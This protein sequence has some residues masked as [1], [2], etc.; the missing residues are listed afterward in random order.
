MTIAKRTALLMRWRGI[1]SQSQLARISGVA[2]SSINR[3]FTHGDQFTPQRTTLL[4]LSRALHTT[5][6]WL[7]DG[8][9]TRSTSCPAS[10]ADHA[11]AFPW[12]TSAHE[13]LGTGTGTGNLI[14]IHTLL[15]QL[16]DPD[17][18]TLLALIRLLVHPK[19]PNPRP[20]AKPKASKAKPTASEAKPRSAKPKANTTNR[21][22]KSPPQTPAPK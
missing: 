12:L 6:H 16:P 20:A 13:D 11:A 22:S 8:I 9:E 15:Q 7:T 5:P 14:E 1:K 3:I 4:R 10:S 19:K 21:P 18:R 2:Q 17:R